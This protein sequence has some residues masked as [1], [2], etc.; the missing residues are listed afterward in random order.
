M[1]R[2]WSQVAAWW[3]R[4]QATTDRRHVALFLILTAAVFLLTCC[5]L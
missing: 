3:M 4:V 1:S 5:G 2:W